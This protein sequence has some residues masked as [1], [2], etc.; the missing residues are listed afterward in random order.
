MNEAFL[1]ALNKNVTAAG[2]LGKKAA[3]DFRDDDI[4]E[5][6]LAVK[7]IRALFNLLLFYQA[8]LL[9]EQDWKEIK[10]IFSSA[11]RIREYRL[12]A[13]R[14]KDFLTTNKK[15]Q[16]QLLDF[17]WGKEKAAEKKFTHRFT[18]HWQAGSKNL[19]KKMETGA[20][21]L[22]ESYGGYF[23]QLS[24]RL[25][26]RP[27]TDTAHNEP[28]HEWRKTLKELKYNLK[29]LTGEEQKQWKKTFPHGQL[30]TID[31][32]IGEW[33][34]W[35]SIAE[36]LKKLNAEWKE[37]FPEEVEETGTLFAEEFILYTSAMARNKLEEISRLW[38]GPSTKEQLT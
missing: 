35:V 28:L 7:R 21:S 10:K 2:R 19:R 6:R 36:K 33:H 29:L 5:F 27:R 14:V 9:T 26:R 1:K 3:A 38:Q 23:A 17:I 32:L 16:Q 31:Q 8:P 18:E 15:S 12:Q 20:L 37:F 13:A 11:G 24:Q 25:I 4:H 22:P 30:S 34:D